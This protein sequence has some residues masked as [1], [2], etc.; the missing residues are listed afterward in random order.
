MILNQYVCNLCRARVES[1]MTDRLVSGVAL[2]LHG[3]E[4][5]GRFTIV[6]DASR[7]DIHLCDKCFRGVRMALTYEDGKVKQ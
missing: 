1:Q 7:G 3:E 5:P 4:A 6:Y 2:R